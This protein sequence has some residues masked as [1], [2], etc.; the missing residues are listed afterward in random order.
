MFWTPPPLQERLA[1]AHGSQCGF[2]TPGFIM[3]M[4]TL[5]RASPEPPSQEE[6]EENLAGNL[7]RCTGYRPIVDAFRAFAKKEA[8]AHTNDSVAANGKSDGGMICPSTGQPCGCGTKVVENGAK[9]GGCGNGGCAN[10]DCAKSG[11]ANGG[12]TEEKLLTRGEPIFPPELKTRK[13]TV[14]SFA[15]SRGSS[16]HRP[17]SLQELLILKKRFPGA[18]LVVGNTEVGIEM[19]FKKLAYPVLIGTTHVAEM[20]AIKVRD[21]GIEFGASVTLTR[22][23]ETCKKMVKER[24]QWETS[25]CAAIAEQ[26]RWFAGN[27]IRNVSS[28]GGN[29]VTGSPISDLNPLWMATGAVFRTA[30]LE[31]KPREVS[32]YNGTNFFS[33]YG[34]LGICHGAAFELQSLF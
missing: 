7:C 19:R 31:G 12:V 29:V 2:C 10:G 28:I 20:N 14:L 26:L 25:G 15:G 30:S 8:Q 3:S 27:Q 6:I 4:Y 1:N 21:A 18:K 5:L 13:N 11:D 33:V 23:M 16:W 22:L 17:S 34:A 32:I 24:P 9:G